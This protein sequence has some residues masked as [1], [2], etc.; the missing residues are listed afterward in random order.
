MKY[1]DISW[2]HDSTDDPYRLV[3]EIGA[4]GYEKRKLEFF[5]DGRVGYASEIETSDT[6]MLGTNRIPDLEVITSQP[7]FSGTRVSEQEFEQLWHEHVLKASS[8]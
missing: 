5:K 7:E 8:G 1:L 3:S 2:Q 6:T 4:D